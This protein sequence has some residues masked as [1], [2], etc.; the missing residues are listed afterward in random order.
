MKLVYIAGAYRASTI[1]EV[2]ANIRRA[3]EVATQV[4]QEGFPALCPHLNSA[5]FDGIAD[6]QV[7]LDGT[8][9][10]LSR[11]DALILVTGWGK[12]LGTRKE[13]QYAL[14]N[15][16][17]VFETIDELKRWKSSWDALPEIEEISKEQKSIIDPINCDCALCKGELRCAKCNEIIAPSAM[18]NRDSNNIITHIVC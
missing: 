9:E 2:R 16:I 5:F 14:Q 10:M 15:N 3:E 1:N 18:Y 6:D 8:M 11:C 17:K 12:S 4:W 13:I 7:F